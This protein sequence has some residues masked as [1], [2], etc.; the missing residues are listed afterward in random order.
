MNE[1]NKF[2]YKNIILLPVIFFL[3]K[4]QAGSQGTFIGFHV[5][6]H[7]VTCLGKLPVNYNIYNKNTYYLTF[8]YATFPN[9]QTMFPHYEINITDIENIDESGIRLHILKTEP[10]LPEALKKI[11]NLDQL[12]ANFQIKYDNYKQRK[13][14]INHF[15]L[16]PLRI[17][18]TSGKVEKLVDF[19]LEIVKTPSINNSISK[20]GP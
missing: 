5:P 12:P 17:N 20:K 9:Q 3:L 13:K 7:D 8:D 19:V 15:G 2:K 10:V 4:L 18:P 11:E 6:W 1:V 16:I 14:Q